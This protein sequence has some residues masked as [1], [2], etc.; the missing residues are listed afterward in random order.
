M[1]CPALT[2]EFIIISKKWPV[3][4]LQAIELFLSLNPTSV[5]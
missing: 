3:L 2:L 4:L 5:S 1:F